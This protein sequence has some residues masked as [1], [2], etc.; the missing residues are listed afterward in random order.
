MTVKVGTK[1]YTFKFPSLRLI[2]KLGAEL[3]IDP[4]KDNIDKIK[5]ADLL[6]KEGKLIEVLKQIFVDEIDESIL[7]EMTPADLAAV[8]AGFFLSGMQISAKDSDG[9]GYL[10]DMI[11]GASSKVL[12]ADSHSTTQSTKSDKEVP[13]S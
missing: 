1:E 3:G 2:K 10:S 11:K 12:H 6:E 4:L 8:V 9:R 7:D 5:Y 13:S